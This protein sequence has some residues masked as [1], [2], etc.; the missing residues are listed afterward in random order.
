MQELFETRISQVSLRVELIV[1]MKKAQCFHTKFEALRNSPK[2]FKKSFK[3]RQ[4]WPRW[5][6][7]RFS[8]SC[9]TCISL[10]FQKEC[11][12]NANGFQRDLPSSLS[13]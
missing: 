1:V 4:L 10:I 5:W 12:G 3:V 8:L 2:E 13:P 11:K 7:T 6:E 9:P